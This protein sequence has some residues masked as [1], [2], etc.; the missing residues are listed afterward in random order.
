[1]L[2]NSLPLLEVVHTHPFLDGT[3]KI[4]DGP[5][6]KMHIL[7]ELAIPAPLIYISKKTSLMP[8]RIEWN[9]PHQSITSLSR[10]NVSK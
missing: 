3:V 1:M 5:L 8:T 10:E 2:L 9:P 4:L 6:H 7:T